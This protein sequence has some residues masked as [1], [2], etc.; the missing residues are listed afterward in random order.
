MAGA[1]RDIFSIICAVL[2]PPLGVF[3]E[4]GCGA[5]LL[6]NILLTC[7]GYIPG[8]IHALYISK[9]LNMPTPEL[10]G[11]QRSSHD[12]LVHSP[13]DLSVHLFRCN[14]LGLLFAEPLFLYPILYPVDAAN[15]VVRQIPSFLL[16]KDIDMIIVTGIHL[17]RK[18]P[19][20][21]P[22]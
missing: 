10:D 20:L 18:M 16:L 19:S 5:D 15:N 6:I 8:I 11:T 2:L 21:S 14:V 3:F 4:R 22:E 9:S 7:L 17:N 12:Y 1:G 13:Q